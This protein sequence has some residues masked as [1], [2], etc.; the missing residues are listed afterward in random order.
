MTCPAANKPVALQGQEN[1]S[2]PG[3]PGRF[4]RWQ[5]AGLR[6]YRPASRSS[7]SPDTRWTVHSSIACAPIAR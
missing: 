7:A 6:L 4:L 1:A 5:G 2:V 3:A